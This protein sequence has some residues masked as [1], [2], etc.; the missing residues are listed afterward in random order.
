ME[1]NGNQRKKKILILTNHSY[2][3]Y[4]FRRELIEEL[5]KHGD[6]SLRMPYR[7]HEEDFMAMGLDCQETEFER[8][9]M[10]PVKDLQLLRTYQHMLREVQPDLVITYSIKPNVYGGLACAL[11]GIPY[12]INVQGLGTAFQKPGIAQMVSAMY[13]IACKKAKTVFFENAGNVQVFLD[14]HILKTGKVCLLPG[15]GINLDEYPLKPY[16]E[17]DAFHFLYLGRIMEE[18]GVSELF[19][20]AH[21]LHERLGEQVVL[22]VVGF[23]E[24]DYMPRIEELREEGTVVFHGFQSNPNPY[25]EAADCVVLPSYHEGM[26]NVLLEAAATGRPVITSDIH[27]CLEAVDAEKSGMLCQVRD[28]DSLYDQML[29][30]TELTRKER[31]RMGYEGRKK[32]EREFDKHL[33]VGKTVKA[34]FE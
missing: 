19:E 21:R 3:L 7:G 18:K 32:M 29:R 28:A 15:A 26:S 2:M 30:M 4:R 8:R 12:C 6:V 16:P 10:N 22:D 9:G 27:G 11:A 33:V 31:E 34:I 14:R 17:N 25:Y 5:M 20:A 13:R 1:E 24:D 23:C